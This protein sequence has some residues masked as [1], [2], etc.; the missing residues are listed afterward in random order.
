MIVGSLTLLYRAS[1]SSKLSTFPAK[2]STT[3]SANTNTGGNK[4]YQN[5]CTCLS[6]AVTAYRDHCHSCRDRGVDAHFTRPRAFN[7]R[8]PRHKTKVVITGRKFCYAHTPEDTRPAHDV[9]SI[10]IQT[11]VRDAIGCMCPCGAK[12][13]RLERLCQEYILNCLCCSGVKID[14]LHISIEYSI[15]RLIPSRRSPRNHATSCTKGAL[16]ARRL[17][18]YRTNVDRVWIEGGDSAADGA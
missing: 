7:E 2:S 11:R 14:H 15:G 5:L 3:A 13:K 17:F 16:R 9:S 12:S 10:T 4:R 1:S 18:R 6:D 8:I